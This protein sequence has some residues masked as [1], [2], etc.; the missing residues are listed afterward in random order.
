MDRNAHFYYVRSKLIN[1][2]PI[3]EIYYQYGIVNNII[4][5]SM[6]VLITNN[7]VIIM[8]IALEI[9]PSKMIIC[10]D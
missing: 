10:F 1:H 4:K 7:D 2:F 5:I 6:N 9:L 8:D 3:F